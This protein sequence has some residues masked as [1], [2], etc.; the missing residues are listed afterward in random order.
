VLENSNLTFYNNEARTG[1]P[2]GAIKLTADSTV[3]QVTRHGFYCIELQS[4]SEAYEVLYFTPDTQALQT[5]WVQRLTQAIEIAK[6]K[7][8][9]LRA[10]IA[11][12]VPPEAAGTT[13]LE[14]AHAR[15][16]L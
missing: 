1:G 15:S 9:S 10:A 8:A 16:S 13:K 5:T 3:D 14:F 11:P 2:V 7:R 6:T 12:I 4:R